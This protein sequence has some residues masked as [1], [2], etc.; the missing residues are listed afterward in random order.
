MFTLLTGFYWL[1]PTGCARHTHKLCR[2]LSE[3]VGLSG[4]A[5]F[6]RISFV[7]MCVCILCMCDVS[8]FVRATMAKFEKPKH[9]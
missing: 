7:Y 6:I 1:L 2:H 5:K 8:L 9:V 4:H 3:L